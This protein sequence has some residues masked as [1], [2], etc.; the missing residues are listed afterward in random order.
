MSNFKKTFV[1]ILLIEL[2][3]QEQ[4]ATKTTWTQNRA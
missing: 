1:N 2:S 3:K 4:S